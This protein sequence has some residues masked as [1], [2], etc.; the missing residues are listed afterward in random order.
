[1]AELLMMDWKIK[2]AA[3]FLSS[4]RKL[5]LTQTAVTLPF[6]AIFAV[7]AF[8]VS[9]FPALAFE[10]MDTFMASCE[11]QIA[12]YWQNHSLEEFQIPQHFRNYAKGVVSFELDEKGRA[13]K[14]KIRHAASESL[15]VAARL[16]YGA[17]APGLMA[18][19]DKSMISAVK[20]CGRLPSPPKLL[21]GHRRYAVIFDTQRFKPLRLFIDDNIQIYEIP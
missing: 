8:F 4:L 1:M 21:S 3:R 13:K 19:L 18:A 15:Y 9:C 16:Q 20:D 6:M 12:A 5:V 10:F 17:R 7:A 11:K 2:N 14:I